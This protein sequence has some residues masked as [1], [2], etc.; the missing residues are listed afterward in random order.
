MN[1]HGVNPV[2]ARATGYLFYENIR[3][4][5]SGTQPDFY[6]RLYLT[7]LCLTTS[8]SRATDWLI[9]SGDCLCESS[10]M[11]QARIEPVL[12][13]PADFDLFEIGMLWI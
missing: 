6:I 11:Q 12:D 7:R 10:A 8:L 3:I 4:C 5:L 1:R 9:L 13:R 2:A